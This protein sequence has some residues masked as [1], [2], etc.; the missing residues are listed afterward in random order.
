MSQLKALSDQEVETGLSEIPGWSVKDG[1][2]QRELK[3]PSFVEAFGFLTSLAI[4]AERM[5]H[6]PEIFNVYNR[7]KLE[8]TTHDANGITTLDFEL[9]K[10]ANKL[11]ANATSP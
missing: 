10:A 8:L 1:R 2:L 6:H 9:A 4:V 7:V 3:F 11:A 5:D